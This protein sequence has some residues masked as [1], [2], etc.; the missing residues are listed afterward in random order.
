[1]IYRKEPRQILLFDRVEEILHPKAH[2]NIEVDKQRLDSTHIFSNMADW[3]RSMLLFKTRKRFLVQV[4]RHESRLYGELDQDL[5]EDYEAQSCW[6][7]GDAKAR[8]ARYGNHICSNHEQLGW[9]MLRL[10]ERFEKHP[11]LSNMNTFKDM[12]RVFQNNVRLMTARSKSVSIQAGKLWSILPT[13]TLRFTIRAWA[14]KCRSAKLTILKI[15]F[16]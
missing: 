13:R 11:K 6:I 1:M 3:N 4:K 7:Y 12:F 16:R 9:D 15:R 2:L 8:N 5:Q 10:I 14:I